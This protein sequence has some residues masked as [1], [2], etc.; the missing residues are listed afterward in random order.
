MLQRR[1]KSNDIAVAS[2]GSLDDRIGIFPKSTFRWRSRSAHYSKA[3][4]VYLPR[5]APHQLYNCNL[6]VR[7][8][9]LP[10]LAVPFLTEFCP[11]GN[12]AMRTIGEFAWIISRVVL[13]RS[14]SLRVIV[15]VGIA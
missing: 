8:S 9:D 14:V 4:L 13:L 6:N 7:S 2:T 5:H 12:H 1:R 10:W 11:T 3:V 15:P